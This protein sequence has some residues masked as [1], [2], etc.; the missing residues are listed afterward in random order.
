M[1]ARTKTWHN[2]QLP[3]SIGMFLKATFQRCNT[4]VHLLHAD[5]TARALG[6]A[7]QHSAHISSLVVSS[8][9]I[10]TRLAA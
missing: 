3:E 6:T 9:S 7:N 2:G 10:E 4:L 1:D 5:I 8:R